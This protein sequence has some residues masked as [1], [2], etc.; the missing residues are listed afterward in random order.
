MFGIS[1]GARG[2]VEEYP[3]FLVLVLANLIDDLFFEEGG[4]LRFQL[5]AVNVEIV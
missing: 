4:V 1:R 2:A 3:P 5:I